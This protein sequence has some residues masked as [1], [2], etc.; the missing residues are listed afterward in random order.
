LA[1][2]L[3]YRNL[4]SLWANFARAG[5]ERLLLADLVEKRADLRRAEEA[6]PGASVVVV[7]LRAPLAVLE[8]RVRRREA[9]PEG[10]LNAARWWFDHLERVT[11]GDH[12]VP[13]E[14]HPVGSV[15]TSIL[16]LVGWLR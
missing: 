6:V 8:A 14:G 10:E 4:A 2:A 1:D 13:T 15:A 3:A 5:A 12:L 16:R 11:V 9:E 7:Q